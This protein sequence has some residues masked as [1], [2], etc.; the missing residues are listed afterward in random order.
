MAIIARSRN[1]TGRAQKAC[2]KRAHDMRSILLALL[3]FFVAA[4][5]FAADTWRVGIDLDP[6]AAGG[7]DFDL[8]GVEPNATDM[9]LMLELSVDPGPV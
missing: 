1:I 3:L 8:M 4:T 2:R 9:D 6:G 7:C 5:A